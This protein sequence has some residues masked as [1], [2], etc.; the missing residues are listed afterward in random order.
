MPGEGHGMK[1]KSFPAQE[2]GTGLRGTLAVSVEVTF[3][4]LVGVD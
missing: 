3:S 4:V 2:I 1:T